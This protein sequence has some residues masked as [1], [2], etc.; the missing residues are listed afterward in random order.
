MIPNGNK[1]PRL[2]SFPAQ[3]GEVVRQQRKL[4]A[5]S[6]SLPLATQDYQDQQARPFY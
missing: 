4:Q 2:L 6:Q 5:L 1:N 3:L